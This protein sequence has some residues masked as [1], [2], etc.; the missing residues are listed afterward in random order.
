MEDLA[1]QLQRDSHLHDPVPAGGALQ[2]RACQP[3]RGERGRICVQWWVQTQH[4][5]APWAAKGQ[6]EAPRTSTSFQ[7]I[8]DRMTGPLKERMASLLEYMVV[9]QWETEAGAS[10]LS[11]ATLAKS[12]DPRGRSPGFDPSST[13]PTFYRDKV[14]AL[15]TWC[16]H[17]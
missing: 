8:E 12:T 10:F 16:P 1:A 4:P 5:R 3:R 11:G 6:E 14:L 7:A 15:C 17:L 13:F 9:V 2:V